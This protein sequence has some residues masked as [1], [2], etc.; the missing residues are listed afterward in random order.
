MLSFEDARNIILS[1]VVPMKA[2]PVEVLDSLGRVIAE[3]VV[4]PINLPSFDN[5]AMDGYAVRISDC[6]RFA[7]LTVSGY[8]PAGGTAVATEVLPGNAIRIMTGAPVPSGCDAIVPLE[9]VEEVQEAEE[10]IWVLKAAPRVGQ[11]IRFAGEDVKCGE[12]VLPAG[13][14]IRV[15]AVS[16]LAS[17]GRTQVQVYRKPVVAILATGDE[18]VEPGQALAEGKLYNSNSV[19][20]AAAVREA[21][22]EAIILGIARDNREHLRQMI[23]DGLRADVL[24]TAAGVSVGDRDFVRDTLAELG[25]NQLFW[26]VDMKP[27]KSMAFG[28]CHGKPVFSLPGNPVSAMITFEEMVRPALLK[29]MGHQKV[30]KPLVTA[31]LQEQMSKK[32]GR[33]FFSRVRLERVNG[34]FLAWNAGNQDTGF[35]QTLL[36]ADALAVLPADRVS[37]AEGEEINVHILSSLLE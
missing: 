8:I 13:T 27:G 5:S 16:V 10:E 7:P 1:N 15:S 6:N 24:I 4:A 3:D 25:V 17:L 29:M 23:A 22:A 37:F 2:Q 12:S 21:G 33:V 30:V 31:T 18:L 9:D 36:H 26:K 28:T 34:K 11:H 19:A 14:L 35:V 32:P 20:L